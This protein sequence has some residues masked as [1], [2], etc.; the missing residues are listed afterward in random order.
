MITVEEDLF[1]CF[2]LDELQEGSDGGRTMNQEI[3]YVQNRM[4]FHEI[5]KRR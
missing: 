1:G 4:E 5:G 2:L 3:I